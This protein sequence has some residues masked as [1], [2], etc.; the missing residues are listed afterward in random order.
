[1]STIRATDDGIIIDP[2]VLD[3]TDPLAD[4]YY[5]PANTDDGSCCYGSSA[6]LQIYTNDQCGYAQYFGFELLDNNGVV[7]A[8]GGQNAG[9]TWQDYTYYDYCLPIN[10][11]CDTYQLVLYDT[12]GNG[13]YAC[14][15]ASAV[16]TSA[17]G[18]TLLYI[19]G[20]CCWSA[21]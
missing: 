9:E 18:D 4:N 20:N 15:Q 8:S 2:V 21:N 5:P 7:V 19:T 12:Y 10:D 6:N 17:N 11:S 16:L 3:C 14:S 1:M 13:W